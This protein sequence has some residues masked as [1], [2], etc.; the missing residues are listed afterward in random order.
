MKSQDFFAI[1]E[2]YDT[3]QN[4]TTV[5]KLDLLADYCD[6]RNGIRILD[7]GCGKAWLLRRWA[8]RFDIRATGLEINPHF[9]AEARARSAAEGLEGRIRIVEGPASE[10]GA[11]PA[12][13]DL[14]LCIGASFALGGMEK[15]V[16]WM[17]PQVT[18]GGMVAIGDLYAKR[19]PLPDEMVDYADA[20]RSLPDTVAM[21]GSHGL[22]LRGLISSSTEDWDRYESLHW[23]A[24]DD[25]ASEN[26]SHPD[27][28]KIPDRNQSAKMRYLKYECEFLGWAIFVGV[29]RG[30]E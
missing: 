17:V 4:P 25:W 26:P 11:Q 21:L 16:T 14:A 20:A 12:S 8:G 29:N 7:V 2:R 1:V 22:V 3:F 30:R 5:E 10:F 27:R 19:L 18:A 23:R 9:A 28:N 24:A 6:V 13:F 15:A